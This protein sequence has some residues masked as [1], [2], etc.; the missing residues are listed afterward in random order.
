MDIK[1]GNV[2]KIW[3]FT[4][5]DKYKVMLFDKKVLRRI[6]KFN[7]QAET[8]ERGKYIMSFLISTVNEILKE[9]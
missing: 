8:G 2:C 6:L 5:R 4:P 7:R 1:F 3:S 9:P